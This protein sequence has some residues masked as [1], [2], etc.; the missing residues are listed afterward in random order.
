MASND[1]APSCQC[2]KFEGPTLPGAHTTL[3]GLAVL[4]SHSATIRSA[5]GYGRPRSSTALT[6]EKIDVVAPTLRASVAT[7]VAVNAGARR[8]LRSA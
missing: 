5:W 2:R 6:T 3:F 4:F 7:A 8:R 1:R